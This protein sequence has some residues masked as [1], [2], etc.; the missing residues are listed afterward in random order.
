[1]AG[2][3]ALP[4]AG[5]SP[6][7]TFDEPPYRLREA[8]PVILADAIDPETGELLSLT[9]GAR[10]ADA[11]AV[12]AMRVQRGT[13]A[14]VQSLGNRYR[15]IELVQDGIQ[16]I[17]DS[18]TREAFAAAEDAGVARLER[19]QVEVDASDPSQT[20]TVIEYRDLLAPRDRAVRRLVFRR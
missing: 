16:Q 20:S 11:F 2:M 9:R 4:P 18:M 6:A 1:M 12:Q 8:P 17:I 10:L 14:C 13:G 5:F 19:V 15:E 7:S 3:T